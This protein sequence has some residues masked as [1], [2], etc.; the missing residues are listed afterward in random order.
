MSKPA[1]HQCRFFHCETEPI[2]E[3]LRVPGDDTTHRVILSECR[4][5]AP[6]G[7]R[8]RPDSPLYA[9]WPTVQPHDWCGS[10]CPDLD[11]CRGCGCT[12]HH[13]CPEGCWWVEPGLCSTCHREGS[14]DVR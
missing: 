7:A 5:N 12:N 11:E 9:E 1:C 14:A 4:R 3:R 8:S 6:T 2:P 13:G 10:F